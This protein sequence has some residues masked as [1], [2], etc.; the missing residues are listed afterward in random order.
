[1]V[2]R[3]PDFDA[4]A[5]TY[6]DLRPQDDNWWELFE[7]VSRESDLRGQRVL[8]VGC[9]TGRLVAA[10]APEPSVWGIDSSAEMLAVATGPVQKKVNLKLARPAD[11]PYKH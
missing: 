8:D 7:L 5:A 11:P 10:L 4:R 2:L 9:G 3:R 1:M 6:D